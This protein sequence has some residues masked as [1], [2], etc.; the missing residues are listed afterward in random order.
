M[1]GYNV[2]NVHSVESES[3]IPESIKRD[4]ASDAENIDKANNNDL[5][6]PVPEVESIMGGD[7]L[8]RENS[9]KNLIEQEKSS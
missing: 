6:I 4:E 9:S 1:D 7:F 8:K 5:K 3:Q 2:P